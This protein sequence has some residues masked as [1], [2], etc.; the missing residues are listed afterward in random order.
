MALSSQK[1]TEIILQLLYSYDFFS[2]ALDEDFH[3]VVG[4][5][6]QQK[7]SLDGEPHAAVGTG[8]QMGKEEHARVGT[9]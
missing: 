4:K 5:T 2:K 9:R 8:V 3:A 6:I 7:P 1:F